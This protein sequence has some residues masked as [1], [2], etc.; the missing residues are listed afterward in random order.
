MS[1]T[2]W[3]GGAGTTVNS[4]TRCLAVAHSQKLS[5]NVP[6]E[7]LDRDYRSE[8][9]LTVALMGLLA[10]EAVIAQRLGRFGRKKPVGA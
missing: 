1:S 8:A 10:E 5:R 2:H 9:A 7:V 6:R 4:G 3:N